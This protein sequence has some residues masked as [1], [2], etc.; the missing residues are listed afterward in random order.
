MFDPCPLYPQKRTC[1]TAVVMSALC[2]KQTLASKRHLSCAVRTAREPSLQGSPPAEA[3]AKFGLMKVALARSDE[4]QRDQHSAYTF[5]FFRSRRTV[6]LLLLGHR[7]LARIC[8]AALLPEICL[9]RF[10]LEYFTGDLLVC[11]RGHRQVHVLHPSRIAP[12][13]Q[14]NP[15]QA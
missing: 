10:C 6:M 11:D 3:G 9:R 1:I 15:A 8:Q 13:T 4:S 2:Q 14:I 7:A 12:D 5:G